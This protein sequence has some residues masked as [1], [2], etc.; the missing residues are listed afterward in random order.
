MISIIIPA[1]R[2]TV[3]D[4][5]KAIQENSDGIDYEI[6]TEEDKDRIGVAKMVDKLL[7]KVNGEMVM[8]LGDDTIPQKGFMTEALKAMAMLPNG[9]GMVGLDDGRAVRHEA[10]HFLLDRRMIPLIGGEIFHT[11]YK[12][13]FCDSELALR[14]RL[15]KRY[16]YAE[17]AKIAH[18]H[19]LLGNAP[20]DK[21]YE[22]VYSQA[23]L[24]HDKALFTKR[25]E[26]IIKG[27]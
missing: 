2:P 4:C 1:I 20:I 25:K 22:R 15:L 13:C 10:T 5:I 19:P 12:H 8:F 9:W 16:A 7:K 6:I 18:N 27:I 3:K 21:D 14:A 23:Y 17:R 26:I 11:G 24:E